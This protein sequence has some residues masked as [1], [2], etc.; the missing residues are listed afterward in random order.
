MR[1]FLTRP[2]K[3]CFKSSERLKNLGHQTIEAPLFKIET[4]PCTE[5]LKLGGVIFTS[6]NGIA[7]TEHLKLD[8]TLPIFTV[9]NKT[10]IEAKKSGFL[11]I[12]S[13]NGAQKELEALIIKSSDDLNGEIV[14]FAGENIRGDL[15]GALSHHGILARREVV[16]RAKAL[17]NLPENLLNALKS[18]EIDGGIFYSIRAA[19]TFNKLIIDSG[20][21]QNLENI[22]AF[23]LSEDIKV[24]LNE[25]NWKSILTAKYPTEDELIYQIKK[26]CSN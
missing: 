23:T 26:Y 18:K 16:Y 6:L 9:G 4:F 1:L 22:I 17:R 5:P 20:L 11:N 14:H 21:K 15:V 13:A 8:K 25:L 3:E 19:T 2:K 10:A 7:S 24:S 12:K